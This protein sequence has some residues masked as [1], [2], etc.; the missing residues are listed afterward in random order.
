MNKVEITNNIFKIADMWHL[1]DYVA[2]DEIEEGFLYTLQYLIN[3]EADEIENLI[4]G[5]RNECENAIENGWQNV[6]RYKPA[7]DLYDAVMVE[8]EE[9]LQ[10]C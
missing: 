7:F 6:D 2:D 8:L 1:T 9:L 10:E 3:Y 4:E 5:L